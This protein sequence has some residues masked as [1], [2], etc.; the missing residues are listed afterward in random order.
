MAVHRSAAQETAIQWARQ[1]KARA[2]C[3]RPDTKDPA[4]SR[5]GVFKE[6]ERNSPRMV[7]P[8]PKCGDCDSQGDFR[9]GRKLISE[10]SSR[11]MTR[12]RRRQRQ[13]T[14]SKSHHSCSRLKPSL[15]LAAPERQASEPASRNWSKQCSI[16]SRPVPTRGILQ[17]TQPFRSMCWRRSIL[18]RTVPEQEV[19]DVAFVR[20]EPVQ[21]DRLHFADIEP[22]HVGGIDQRPLEG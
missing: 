12:G 3:G 7:R 14:D 11:S 21:L 13:R 22:I 16:S 8:F 9:P 19:D 6:L 15:R 4:Q 5:P 2:R 17:S 18:E 1:L 10:R 20:L